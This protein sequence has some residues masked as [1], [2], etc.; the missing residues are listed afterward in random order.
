MFTALTTKAMYTKPITQSH[1]SKRKWRKD[2]NRHF[3]EDEP[4][5]ANKHRKKDIS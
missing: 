1:K 5:T 4:Q 2:L 3:T